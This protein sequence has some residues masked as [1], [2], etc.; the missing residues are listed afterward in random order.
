MIGLLF[1]FS[2]YIKFSKKRGKSS[3]KTGWKCSIEGLLW[4]NRSYGKI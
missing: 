1:F 3:P 4:Y 2:H